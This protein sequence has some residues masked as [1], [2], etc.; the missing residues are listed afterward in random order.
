M[1]Q[2][3][4]NLRV[5]SS[6]PNGSSGCHRLGHAVNRHRQRL[7]RQFARP[8]ADRRRC[9]DKAVVRIRR[10]RAVAGWRN[11]CRPR[12]GYRSK[13]RPCRPL[14]GLLCHRVG[15]VSCT[16]PAA[17]PLRARRRSQRQDD[18]HH[19]GGHPFL[20][21]V[22][23]TVCFALIGSCRRT[24]SN[25]Q[26]PGSAVCALPLYRDSGADLLLVERTGVSG[27]AV[28]ITAWPRRRQH[29]EPFGALDRCCQLRGALHIWLGFTAAWLR[30][31]APRVALANGLLL[32]L[33]FADPANTIYL[34]TFYAE[35]TALLAAYA[36]C[37]L[38]LLEHGAARS[39]VR[40]LALAMAAFAL[41]TSKSSTCYCRWLVHAC[42]SGWISCT[43]AAGHGRQGDTVR[44][45]RG[46]CIAG[47][48]ARS[49]QRRD[50]AIDM[51]NRA[52]VTFTGL[53][54]NARD[55]AATS[56]RLG[57]DA[58]CLRYLGKRAWQMDDYPAHACPSLQHVTRGREL[59]ALLDEPDMA[60]RF[61]WT[62]CSR[63]NRGWHQGSGSSK[64]ATSRACLRTFRP[65]A[66]C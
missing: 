27:A 17:G 36:L 57:V 63:L 56:A 20:R 41:A 54:P 52:D 22:S 62:A 35:W 2:D 47:R 1:A 39:T 15:A 29:D 5:R 24:S 25:P 64:A 13:V 44:C 6:A 30:R 66:P 23:F 40:S 33:L 31:D 50:P 51:F 61:G 19:R 21:G 58:D 37:G 3:A 45:S 65:S 12:S 9:R 14:R 26:Q 11:V 28:A 10:F 48:A 34:N 16:C 60:L 38:M 53:L 42:Y 55:P 7:K 46:P 43:R 18:Q 32:P 49:R 4:A 8:V 59:I